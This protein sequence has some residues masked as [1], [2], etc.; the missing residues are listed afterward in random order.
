MSA[1]DPKVVS[2]HLAI[3]HDVKPI[4]HKKRKFAG[5][6]RGTLHKEA[7]KME[8]IGFTKDNR[9]PYGL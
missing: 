2:H 3:N 9:Y 7:Q 6:K 1:I 4:M 8:K 5:E